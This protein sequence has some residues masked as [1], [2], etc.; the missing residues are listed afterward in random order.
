MV[1]L[2]IDEEDGLAVTLRHAARKRQLPPTLAALQD[3]FLE[4]K[5]VS[6]SNQHRLRLLYDTSNTGVKV[7]H[8]RGKSREQVAK[9]AARIIHMEPYQPLSLHATLAAVCS[10]LDQ[11]P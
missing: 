7:I 2:L 6:I 11:L 9:I 4:W 10:R 1:L 8:L 3:A 5:T